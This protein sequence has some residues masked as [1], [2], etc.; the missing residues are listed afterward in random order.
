MKWQYKTGL[1]IKSSAA[2]GSDGSVCVGAQSRQSNRSDKCFVNC[3]LP[4]D[5]QDHNSNSNTVTN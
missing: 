5:I 1:A 3:C 4:R 2:I